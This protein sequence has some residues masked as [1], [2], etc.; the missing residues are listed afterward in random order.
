MAKT[1]ELILSGEIKKSSYDRIVD[2][3][4]L[5]FTDKK[6][7]IDVYFEFPRLEGDITLEGTKTVSIEITDDFDKKGNDTTKMVLNTTL[8]MVR[9]ED[10]KQIVQFSSGG[11]ILRLIGDK[12]SHPFRLRKNR[13]FK[14][15]IS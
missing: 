1:T 4:R 14:I 13:N 6:N 3:D 11:I 2:L 5:E 12:N 9:T 10:K 8:Y 15:L 7:K